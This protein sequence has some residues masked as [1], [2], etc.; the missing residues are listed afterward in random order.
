ML[1]ERLKNISTRIEHAALKGGRNPQDIKLVAVSK[2]HSTKLMNEYLNI[3]PKSQPSFHKQAIFGEAYV[4]E[5]KNKVSALSG[6]FKTHLIGAFQSN[7]V[8]DAI[9]LFDVIQSVHKKKLLELINTEAEKAKKIQDIYLQINISQDDDKSG[10]NADE[11]LNIVKCDITRLNNIRLC[12]LMTITK[13]YDD[14]K[15][16]RDDFRKMRQLYNEILDWLNHN[17]SHKPN[18]FEL[19]M[20]MSDDFDIAVEEGATMIRIGSLLFGERSKK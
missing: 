16:T 15:E 12:G 4:Q 2:L 10:F 9:K 7:K 17:S 5:Y 13:Q 3:L 11:A 1:N 19:S 18:S 8:K 20:G 14:P 6:D